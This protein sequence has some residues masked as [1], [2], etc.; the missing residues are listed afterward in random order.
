MVVATVVPVELRLE[1]VVA[2]VMEGVVK[3]DAEEKEETMEVA[4][5]VVAKV[6]GLAEVAMA[7]VKEVVVKAGVKVGVMAAVVT[8][9]AMAVEMVEAETGVERVVAQGAAQW[10]VCGRCAT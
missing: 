9:G 5:G 3:V 1:K 4:K 7:E 6:E 2:A 10:V 8:V